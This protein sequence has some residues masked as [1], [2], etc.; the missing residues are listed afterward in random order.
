MKFFSLFNGEDIHMEKWEKV[1]PAHVF[2]SLLTL[3]QLQEKAELSIKDYRK[4]QQ[5]KC[6]E[7]KKAAKEEGFQSGLEEF[8]QHILHLDE[9]IKQCRLEMQSQIL[10]LALQAA[11][12][13]VGEALKINPNAIIDIVQNSL[14]SAIQSKH[15]KIFVNKEDKKRLETAQDKI[16]SMLEVVETFAIEARADIALGGCMIE[17]EAGIVNASL[18]NQWRAL[19]VAFA[20]FT[21]S[22]HPKAPK[23]S[24]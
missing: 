14:K 23:E 22:K 9:T 10:P 2:S 15:V 7:V 16:K 24:S 21:K 3:K 6:K 11:K 1:I 18:E 4:K 13:I 20:N 12:K 19:E 8:N 5:E 17:T